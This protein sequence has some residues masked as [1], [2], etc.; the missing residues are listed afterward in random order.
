VP[1][2]AQTE[3]G[4]HQFLLTVEDELIDM[5]AQSY[6]DMGQPLPAGLVKRSEEERRKP[7]VQRRQ[8]SDPSPSPSSQ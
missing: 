7:L 3:E 2:D 5:A 8:A 1:E 6:R 4:L